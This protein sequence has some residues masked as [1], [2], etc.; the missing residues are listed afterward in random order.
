[1]SDAALLALARNIAARVL[2]LAEGGGAEVRVIDRLIGRLELGRSRYGE[3]VIAGDPR[4]WR[5]ELADELLD[6]VV[7]DTIETLRAED[8]AHEE[9]QH[10]AVAE[11]RGWQE[12]DHRTPVGRASVEIALD[13][14]AGPYDEIDFDRDVFDGGSEG[15]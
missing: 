9:V 3:L 1:M 11:L 8:A 6:A 4:D 10:Q 12:R 15:G 7:Y 2:V 5:R 14:I 13:D